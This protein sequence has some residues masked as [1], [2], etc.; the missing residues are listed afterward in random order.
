[1]DQGYM[2]VT[3]MTNSDSTDTYRIRR[4]YI[5]FDLA[6]ITEEHEITYAHVRIRSRGFNGSPTPK[7]QI[8]QGTWDYT[9]AISDF[10]SFTGVS[11]I[12]SPYTWAGSESN[13]SM[14]LNQA[15]RD[16]L[17]NNRGKIVYICIREYDHDVLDSPP[18]GPDF[19]SSGQFYGT[20]QGADDTYDPQMYINYTT[21][22]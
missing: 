12:D 18:S 2:D 9:L 13:M 17:N 16:Y 19:D 4:S 14:V 5:A 22:A 3:V 20:G 10:D 6:E 8:F 15:G 1:G 7:L 11:L 21:P